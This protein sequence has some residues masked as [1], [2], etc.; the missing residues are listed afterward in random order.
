M[1]A[2]AGSPDCW[3][4]HTTG[5]CRCGRAI[6]QAP[7]ECGCR[8]LSREVLGFSPDQCGLA[9]VLNVVQSREELRTQMYNE[10]GSR[11]RCCG[12]D[13]SLDGAGAGR[14]GND[15]TDLVQVRRL[16]STIVTRLAPTPRLESEGEMFRHAMMNAPIGC[17]V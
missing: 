12:R 4:E 16:Q 11:D 2:D 6:D 9:G 15:S 7:P 17:K 3:S 5:H 1:T 14:L 10:S 8:R 13:V